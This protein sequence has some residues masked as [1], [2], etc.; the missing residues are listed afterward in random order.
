MQYIFIRD[1][2]VTQ[3]GCGNTLPEGAQQVADFP[4]VVGLPLAFYKDDW[5][6]K[7]QAELIKEGII[8]MPE[9]YEWNDGETDIV[10]KEPEIPEMPEQ[11]EADKI[12][13]EI[14]GL[15]NYLTE[16]DYTVIKCVELGLSVNEEY[17]EIVVK[18][19]ETRAKINELESKLAEVKGFEGG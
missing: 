11:T 3:H 16:T 19:S 17:P 9:G 18:R 15:K 7:T 4:G 8:P 6:M 1:G 14:A 13:T 2:I 5:S 12:E 10:K